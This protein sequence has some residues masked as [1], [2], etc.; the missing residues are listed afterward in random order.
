[1]QWFLELLEELGIEYRVGH[2]AKIRTQETRKQK[3]G[4]RD[5]RF[6]LTLLREDRF[7][8]IW[9]PSTEQRD[10]QPCCGIVMSGCGCEVECSTRCRRSHSITRCDKVVAYG[11]GKGNAHCKPCLYHRTPLNDEMSCSVCMN[12]SRSGST[13]FQMHRPLLHGS[14]SPDLFFR[15]KAPKP[16]R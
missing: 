5:A 12:N 16:T 6:L 1:M 14:Q 8:E 4:R 10:L 13:P 9:M 3:H 11:V 7:P 2:P 15:R